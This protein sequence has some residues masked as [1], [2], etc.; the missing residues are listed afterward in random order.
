MLKL[1][2]D[3]LAIAP[4]FENDVYQTRSG[5]TIIKPDIAKS[6]TT[7]GIIKYMGPKVRELHPGDYVFYTAYDG[8]LWHLPGYDGP[9]IILPERFIVAAKRTDIGDTIVP[10]L[11][12]RTREGEYIP[13]NYEQSIQLISESFVP[14]PV[15][16]DEE[17]WDKKGKL[18]KQGFSPRGDWFPENEVDD[19]E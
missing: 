18:Q 14:V 2:R 12:F 15:K 10:G 1:I 6:R 5:V 8:L 17:I 13:A 19:D 7:Q 11:Y 16:H 4:I 9:L 3:L